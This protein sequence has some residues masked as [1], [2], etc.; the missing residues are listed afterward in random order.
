MFLPK[1]RAIIKTYQR[2][3]LAV[4]AA[5]ASGL[6]LSAAHSA[7]EVPAA[8][9][10]TSA[11]ANGQAPAKKV[12]IRGY[13]LS[14]HNVR[15]YP[16]VL[17]SRSTDRVWFPILIRLDGTR[18]LAG[19]SVAADTA[20]LEPQAQFLWSDDDGL[21]WSGATK[22]EYPASSIRLANGDYLLLPSV[23]RAH[24]DGMAQYSQIVPRGKREIRKATQMDL[25]ITGLP[26]RP[27]TIDLEDGRDAFGFTGEVLKRKNG[28]F[29]GM[30]YG[31]YIGDAYYHLVSVSSRDGKNWK[32]LST[33]ATPAIIPRG[34]GGEGPCEASLAR[35]KDGRLMSI[36][37][38]GSGRTFSQAWSDD[39]GKT[40]TKP[41]IDA[42]GDASLLMKNENVRSVQPSMVVLK[43]G[44]VVLSCGRPGVSVWINEKGDGVDWKQIDISG[45]HNVFHPDEPHVFTDGDA[46]K[47]STS[48]YTEVVILRNGD[49]LVIYDRLRGGWDNLT[50]DPKQTNSVWV[51]RMAITPRQKSGAG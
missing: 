38:I 34:W 3:M 46:T 37:R 35:L 15:L 5:T 39:D 8:V 45:H 4:L 36:F 14:Q 25:R 26:H 24:P 12:P 19:M 29:I 27:R 50:T 1:A 32:Y 42:I 11:T 17:V 2:S 23:L 51:V 21:T 16:P 40:W 22:G 47:H 18:L 43:D 31:K 49:L 33:I 30:L 6:I 20:H 28:E 9:S 48:G 13:S 7:S 44:T 10:E 41:R